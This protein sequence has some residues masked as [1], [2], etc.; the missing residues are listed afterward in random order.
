MTFSLSCPPA[1]GAR[2]SISGLEAQVAHAVHSALADQRLVGAVV[3]VY[4]HGQALCR[5]AAGWADREARSAMEEDT[6]FRWASASK[7]VVSAAVLRLVAQGRV[8]LDDPITAWLPDF[9]PRLPD[10]REACITVRQLLSHTAGLGYR[11]LE[12]D[13]QGAY[14]QAGVSDGMDASGIDLGENLRRIA[15]VPLLYAPGTAWGYSLAV[16]VLGGV[17]EALC[18]M[19]L[20]QAVEALVTRPLGMADAGFVCRDAARL[21]TAYVNGSPAPHRLQEGEVVAPFEGT[22]GIPYSPARALDAGAYPSG[23]AGMVGTA[24]DLRHLLEALRT[25]Q[26][27]WMPEHLIAE[28]GR[29]QTPGQELAAGPGLGFGLGFSVL[30]DP[31]LAR[32]PESPGTWRWGG[33]Y[34]HAWWVDRARGLTVVAMTNTLY[35]GMSGRFV[36][37]LRDAVYQGL[38]A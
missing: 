37:D 33:A 2:H 30:R 26:G 34:G 27:G 29:D 19:A 9:R 22:V 21:A 12:P 5:M 35:E 6:V 11:F 15:S 4:Q 3:L 20:P 32:S 38:Q 23:G 10:G 18:G 8:A 31:A 16:D 17:V 13:G 28:M 25:G 1:T 24:D 36:T 14:A 7:P